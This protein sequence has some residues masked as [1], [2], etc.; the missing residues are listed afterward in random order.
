MRSNNRNCGIFGLRMVKSPLIFLNPS[1]LPLSVL[2]IRIW[3]RLTTNWTNHRDKQSRRNET[4]ESLSMSFRNGKCNNR[5]LLRS[6]L[7]TPASKWIYIRW[8]SHKKSIWML[9][10]GN[11]KKSWVIFM[12]S[13]VQ[14]M[15]TDFILR[16]WY[17]RKT[18][19]QRW[20]AKLF[21]LIRERFVGVMLETTSLLT[22]VLTVMSL[23]LSSTAIIQISFHSHYSSMR[24]PK[25]IFMLCVT[26]LLMKSLRCHILWS[27]RWD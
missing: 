12:S 5:K 6:A 25:F 27:L 2:W 26:F 1:K 24:S 3:N 4:S 21:Q 15:I 11:P 18:L 8:V 22:L 17:K 14:R 20:L 7:I 10:Q 23:A 9:V 19:F 13:V 16:L